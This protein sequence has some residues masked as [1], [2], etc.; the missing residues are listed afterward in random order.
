METISTKQLL[1]NTI[2]IVIIIIIIPIG[3]AGHFPMFLYALISEKEKQTMQ[4]M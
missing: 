4:M 2:I 1:F 3:V